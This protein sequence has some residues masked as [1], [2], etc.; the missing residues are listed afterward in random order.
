MTLGAL[1]LVFDS[2][3]SLFFSVFHDHV[4]EYW[5]FSH[6]SVSLNLLKATLL[7]DS[8]GESVLKEEMCLLQY[9][10]MFLCELQY[11]MSLS[12]YWPLMFHF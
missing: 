6:L 4:T 12:A 5:P 1:L 3:V 8:T 11:H 9:T 7:S 2:L 10:L